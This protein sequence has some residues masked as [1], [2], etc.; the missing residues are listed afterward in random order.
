MLACS[1]SPSPDSSNFTN[2]LHTSPPFPSFSTCLQALIQE[3]YYCRKILNSILQALC[4]SQS[5]RNI[6]FEQD[7][8]S[9]GLQDTEVNELRFTQ[10]RESSII[11]NPPNVTHKEDPMT[12]ADRL[13]DLSDESSKK[14]RVRE[15]L[16]ELF[17]LR[18]E[19][20][21]PAAQ[22]RPLVPPMVTSSPGKA[23]PRNPRVPSLMN[24]KTMSTINLHEN[25]RSSASAYA[26]KGTQVSLKDSMS[27]DFYV[28]VVPSPPRTHLPLSSHLSS[29][30]TTQT[31]VVQ[32]SK[33]LSPTGSNG[34]NI[35]STQVRRESS[36]SL[37]KIQLSYSEMSNEGATTLP[38]TDNNNI[39]T[40][41]NTDTDNNDNDNNN[42]TTS[43]LFPSRAAVSNHLSVQKRTT[44]VGEGGS[45]LL[46]KHAVTDSSGSSFPSPLSLDPTNGGVGVS[47]TGV[48]GNSVSFKED[49]SQFNQMDALLMRGVALFNAKP[50]KGVEFLLNNEVI[51]KSPKDLAFFFLSQEDI[52]AT[53]LGE[54]LS[55]PE[56]KPVL[57]AFTQELDFGSLT[58]DDALRRYLSKF[59]LPG[60]AQK[61]DRMMETFA[62]RFYAQNPKGVFAN[63]DAAYVLA[64]S[65][66][67]LN[68]DAH[69]PAI[70]KQDKMTKQ[71]FIKNNTGINN[72]NNIDQEYLEQVYERIQ[73]E[74]IQLP[75]G[76]S[77][78]NNAEK[79]GW[80]IKQG[81]KI[82]TWKRR[83]FVLSRN[84][85]FYFKNEN[86]PEPC[87]IIPLENLV[88]MRYEKKNIRESVRQSQSQDFEQL[89]AID[90]KQTNHNN[91]NNN[92]NKNKKAAKKKW[93]FT[94]K[95][96]SVCDQQIK[97]CKL[98]DGVVV[99]GNHSHYIISASSEE[100]REEWISSITAYINRD[101]FFELL[102]QKKTVLRKHTGSD[103][104]V[105]DQRP[106]SSSASS[107][108]LPTVSSSTNLMSS[109]SYSQPEPLRPLASSFLSSSTGIASSP[110]GTPNANANR[111]AAA[112]IFSQSKKSK[113]SLLSKG[114]LHR[115][116][117]KK[118]K[119]SLLS[120]ESALLPTE[121]PE[122]AVRYVPTTPR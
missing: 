18:T 101:P 26:R 45:S 90:T 72:G 116:D 102:E 43:P 44:G 79:K 54:Y 21:I 60:E 73:K 41:N 100:E 109:M 30:S 117:E 4:N 24:Q 20:L 50:S 108:Q 69:N 106:I 80:L 55:E 84:C 81:G 16:G 86:D 74:K 114:F 58:L 96:S 107:Y 37:V 15:L 49:P 38:D 64:F 122:E 25:I 82:K 33:S 2:Q 83:W 75:E 68:T 63:A 92:N 57:E 11:L 95:P 12:L 104:T 59:R 6:L 61:I 56:M 28:V 111:S 70:R 93:L 46:R 78:F 3:L 97:S 76:L 31:K 17:R 94:L 89:S 118:K 62:Q 48:G 121:V 35:Y 29:F 36:S 22:A 120:Y 13:L 47:G 8:I 19:L 112:A 42:E 53:K 51:G 5:F 98:Q 99:K 32:A 85:L 1:S 87:G 14:V 27:N 91:H 34:E 40:N 115:F 119:S 105:L 110:G 10:V 88:V 113:P 71:Q 65:I 9:L 103:I 77:I 23:P 39:N 67:M 66:I 52:S 7:L